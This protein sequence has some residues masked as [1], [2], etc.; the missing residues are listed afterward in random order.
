MERIF[1][2]GSIDETRRLGEA[3]GRLLKAGDFLALTG[4]LGAG[5]TAFAG[6]IARGLG[7]AE[8]ITSPTFT[9]INQYE[10]AIP[11]AHM[12]AYRLGD[13]EELEK[14]GY[15][16][17]LEGFVVVLEWAD[18]MECLV[19]EDALRIDFKVLDENRRRITM[20]AQNPRFGRIIREMKV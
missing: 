18:R 3:L 1:E 2:T 16:D 19:P 14:I 20:H 10:A 4:D 12:D 7:I 5:K 9:I 17:Y 6:G 8:D 15:Y 13:A 11:M